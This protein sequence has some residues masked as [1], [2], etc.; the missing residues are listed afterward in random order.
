LF[1]F[2]VE[3]REIAGR[4]GARQRPERILEGRGRAADPQLPV[5]GRLDC[6]SLAGVQPYLVER[7]DGDRDLMNAPSTSPTAMPGGPSSTPTSP[8]AT[9]PSPA[10]FCETW[11]VSSTSR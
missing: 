2:G 8:P 5:T 7:R 3:L 4:E 10:P 6:D 1:I 11:S 9:A